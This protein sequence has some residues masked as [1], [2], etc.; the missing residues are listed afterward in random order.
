MEKYVI[1]ITRQFGSMGRPIAKKMSEI[2]DIEYYDRDIV[3]E[4]GRKLKLATS[5]VSK[6]EENAR[7]NYFSMRFPLGTHTTDVQDKIFDTQRSIM[8][9]LAYSRSCIIVGRCADFI[10]KDVKNCVRI[11]I[12]APEEDRFDNC[13]KLLLMSPEDARKSILDVDRARTAYHLRYAGYKPDDPEYKDIMINS[14][15][16]GVEG[17]A[18]YLCGLIKLKGWSSV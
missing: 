11:H 16:L 14:S 1:T 4:T 8:L 3:E 9:D 17:T 2:L 6:E 7:G 5:E 10:L 18:E 15:L 12:Y 13:V